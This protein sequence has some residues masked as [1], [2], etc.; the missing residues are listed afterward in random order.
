MTL[1]ITYKAF[2]VTEMPD[3]SFQRSTGYRTTEDLPHKDLLIK[4]H[5]SSLNYKDA[6][7][8]TGNKG[9]TRRYPHTPGVDASGE[10]ITSI[11]D[12]FSPG[13]M[14]MVTGYDLGMNTSGGFGQ[15]ISIPSTWALRLPGLM[16]PWEAMA[17]GTAG[18][19][20][21]L[22]VQKLMDSG[23]R[24][25]DGE[26]LVT[27]T[28]GGVGSHAAVILKKEGYQVVALSLGGKDTAF[29]ERIGIN[30]ILTT[31]DLVDKMEKGLLSS[32]WAGV[33]DSVGGPVLVSA[34]KSTKYGGV[35]TSC[36]NVAG[37]SL[38]GLTVYP[39]IIRGVSLLGVASAESPLELKTRIWQKLSTT[40]KPC[41]LWDRVK[42]IYLH[43]LE[44]HIFQMLEGKSSG[45][46]VVNIKDS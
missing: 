2:V 23:I 5:Y 9:V 30:R 37:A 32:R 19:A 10:V 4:V 15:Y 31:E 44:K 28:T 7:S 14:V 34:L 21:A 38:S 1:N 36:G 20:G 45:R 8:A 13:N 27:G 33:I 11:D 42:E 35:V 17:I 29:L 46:I 3:G 43:E 6:L 26:I 18:F 12:A 16:T 40:W 24:P 39:F 41:E 22:S 25:D